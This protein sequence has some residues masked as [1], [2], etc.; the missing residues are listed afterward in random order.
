MDD[1]YDWDEVECVSPHR[2]M[3]RADL[4][5]LGVTLLSRLAGA[6]HD[7]LQIAEQIVAGHANYLTTQHNFHQEAA[8]EI[9][10]LVAGDEDE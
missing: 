1:E 7:T 5:V 4:G 8:L 3:T 6:V 2:R 10:T 9:E